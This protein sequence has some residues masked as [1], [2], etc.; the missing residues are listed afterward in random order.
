MDASLYEMIK[1]V[2]DGD[3]E[4]FVSI[5]EKFDPLIKKFSRKLNYEE[6][7][8]D[9]II[10]LI[11]IVTNINLNNFNQEGEG[12]LVNYIYSAIKHKHIDLYRMYVQ[13]RREDVE[14]NLEI[15]QDT[16]N[17]NIDEKIF[18]ETL[19]NRLSPIQKTIL[20]E[21]FI[22]DHSDVEIATKL[23]ISR[24]AVNKTKKRALE[25]LRNYLGIN[26]LTS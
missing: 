21:K 18:I 14:I 7:E 15:L 1:H 11:N 22:K 17:F 13:K 5:K 10:S 16:S 19:L 26:F 6:A 12:A 3:M 4:S 24:Q 25:N 2:E 9:L 8:T 23:H 20:E